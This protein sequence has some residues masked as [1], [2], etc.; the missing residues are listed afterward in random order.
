MAR[1]FPN[2]APTRDNQSLAGLYDMDFAPNEGAVRGEFTML[3]NAQTAARIMEHAGLA[4]LIATWQAEDGQGKRPGPKPWLTEVNVLAL[5]LLLALSRRAPLFQEVGEVLIEASD[6]TLAAL[7]IDPARRTWS[8]KAAYHRAY[9]SYRRLLPLIDPEP[10]SLYRRLTVQE[11]DQV[12]AAWVVEENAVKRERAHTMANALL[13]GTW[14]L[15]PRQVRRAYKGDIAMDATFVKSPAYNGNT[16]PKSSASD[17][18]HYRSSDPFAGWY[19]RDGNHAG[20]SELPAARAKYQRT[21]DYVGWGREAHTAV[22]YGKDVPGI[23]LAVSLDTPSARLPENA[24]R[25]VEHLKRNNMPVGH[26][27]TDRAYLPGTKPAELARPLRARGYRLVFDYR[28]EEHGMGQT[29]SHGG[30]IQ[31]EGRWYCPSMPAPLVNATKDHM[32]RKESD[33]EYIDEATYRRRIEQRKQYELHLKERPDAEGVARYACP[34][35]GPSATVSCPRR[36]EHPKA[37]DKPKGRVLKVMLVNPA[38]R[39]CEQQSMKISP[40]EG[41]KYAQEYPYK[42][43]QWRKHYTGGRQMVESLNASLKNGAHM[44]IDDT[45]MRPRRGFAAQI[46]SLAVMV[47]ATNT[48]KIIAWL[49]EQIGVTPL[50][51]ASVKRARRRERTKGFTRADEFGPAYTPPGGLPPE[52]RETT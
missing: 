6:E 22:S 18:V 50:S 48:R 41:E 2:S 32:L 16:K 35:V 44:S 49:H 36:K 15:L 37:A 10:A 29:A 27:V 4:D 21:Q 47:A 12:K 52:R 39:V 3:R 51:S 42:S 45:Q 19:K 28:A 11:C 17:A 1:T 5:L 20:P 34:A 9:H 13:Y 23:V 40:L 46:V 38:P 31:V 33:P 8:E 14:M 24:L 30:A 25:M 7:G 26:V 43:E